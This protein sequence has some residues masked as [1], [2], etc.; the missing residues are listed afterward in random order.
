MKTFSIGDIRAA[1]DR[2]RFLAGRSPNQPEGEFLQWM[3]RPLSRSIDVSPCTGDLSL[4][5]Q[6]ASGALQN[7][8]TSLTVRP[9]PGGARAAHCLND[10]Q[11]PFLD[12]PQLHAENHVRA[13]PAQCIRAVRTGASGPSALPCPPVPTDRSCP[14]PAGRSTA[15]GSGSN[16]CS[17]A[18]SR[19]GPPPLPDRLPRRDPDRPAP[20]AVATRRQ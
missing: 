12:P 3:P 15:T 16:A 5:T 14:H 4:A 19:A 17:S 18:A 13:I 10:T 7:G 9:T 8:T 11:L 6:R 1:G 2:L 20:V